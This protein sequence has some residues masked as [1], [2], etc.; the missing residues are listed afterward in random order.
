MVANNIFESVFNQHAPTEVRVHA[1]YGV[2]I[3]KKSVEE[4][5][6]IYGKHES[7]IFRWCKR[8]E[9]TGRVEK[10]MKLKNPQNR[11]LQPEHLSWILNFI[12]QEPLSYLHEISGAFRSNFQSDISTSTIFRVLEENNFTNKCVERRAM[13]ISESDISRF[14]HEINL[15]HVKPDQ[16]LFIDEMSTDNR[17]MIRK[18]GWF[19]RGIKP[20]YRSYFKR[21]SRISLLSFLG[22]NGIVETVETVGTFDRTKFFHACCQLLD[23]GKIQ[24]YPGF[25]SV[26]VLDGA[27]IHVDQTMISYFR[28]RGIFVI[29]LPKYSPFFN[30]IEIV[31]GLIKRECRRIYKENGSVT[32]QRLTLMSVIANFTKYDCLAL[33]EKCGYHLEGYFSP[34][35]NYDFKLLCE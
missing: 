35:I 8:F 24:M 2:K 17:S 20:I 32:G 4:I 10:R 25:L 7:T 34:H 33:F 27:S 5:A 23:S 28:T 21:G 6:Y 29:Y 31:F 12:K 9:Q 13:E 11:K 30:P 3:L 22:V 26:W 15:L 1:V 18:K 19:L 16:L 14:T